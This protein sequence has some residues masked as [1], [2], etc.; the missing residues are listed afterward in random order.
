MEEC[1]HDSHIENRNVHRVVQTRI[2]AFLHGKERGKVINPD[3]AVT[4]D[5]A[6]QVDILTSRR[7]SQVQELRLFDVTPWSMNLE[8]TDWR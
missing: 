2:P 1:L 8:T 6:L 5:A 4:S 3:G 7:S